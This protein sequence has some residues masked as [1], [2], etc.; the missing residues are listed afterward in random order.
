LIP[1]QYYF[2]KQND[3]DEDFHEKFNRKK[4]RKQAGHG[5]TEEQRLATLEAK[6]RKYDPTQYKSVSTILQEQGEEAE[7][8]DDEEMG[9]D[10]E[11]RSD[12]LS[13]IQ[14]VPGFSGSG[15]R[16]ELKKRL[17]EKINAL[18]AK[19]KA[20]PLNEDGTDPLESEAGR[21]AK[22]RR[23][24]RSEGK[25]KEKEKPKRERNKNKPEK[26]EKEK[27]GSEVD[28]KQLVKVKAENGSS[29]IP[30]ALEFATFDFS[31]GKPVPLY[32]KTNKRKPNKF[33]LLK[34][35]KEQKEK[36]EALKGTEEGQKLQEDESWKKVMK[37]A[38]GEKVKDDVDKIKKSIKRDQAK[39][40]KSQ[41][42]WKQRQD[43]QSKRQDAAIKK[44]EGNIEAA[45]QKRKDR[46][47]GKKTKRPGFEGKKTQIINK[48][49]KNKNT[50]STTPQK[51]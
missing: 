49:N 1:A 7:R 5:R 51:S 47:S 18:R 45:R 36:I 4:R 17:R 10:G 25:E 24:D 38:S 39:K 3:A 2:T 41:N 32:L 40:K 14:I 46:K 12:D 28:G 26:G 50:K 29:G 23:V 16:E 44:R 42:Q 6:R 30:S 15:D 8:Q 9:D 33:A 27:D 31:S 21:P 20:P 19:R 11:T 43:T 34:Q 22:K 13:T 37:K 48:N 35:A